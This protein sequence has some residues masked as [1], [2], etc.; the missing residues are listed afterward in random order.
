MDLELDLERFLMD[1]EM[2]DEENFVGIEDEKELSRKR[3]RDCY[4]MSLDWVKRVAKN[5]C[6]PAIGFVPG[7]SKW[8]AYGSEEVWK[9]VLLAKE[10]MQMKVNVDSNAIWEKKLKMH[11]DMYDDRATKSTTRCSRRLVSSKE[12]RLILFSRKSEVRDCYESSFTGS[13]SEIEPEDDFLASNYKKKWIPL[14]RY[15]QAEI[16]P[17]TGE[18]Y[19]TETRWLGTRVWPLEKTEHRS[20]LIER[21]QMGKGRQGSCGCEFVGSLECVRL[22]IAEKRSRVKLELGSAF[23]KWKFDKMGEEVSSKWTR[24]EEKKFAKIIKSNP[25][26]S[27]TS[28]WDELTTY[29]KN[30]TRPVLV[31]YYFNVYLL[32]RRAHQNRSNPSKVDSDDDELEKIGQKINESIGPTLCSPK[33]C[34]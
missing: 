7:M 30:K 32:R 17:W 25:K 27:G 21:E 13:R 24:H 12:T 14:G 34:I 3:K 16:P 18:T 10:A 2:K 29:F 6:D 4:L 26:S 9:Q 8:E 22:H 28:F 5:P 20:S 19:E 33:R 15:F 11:P 23:A 1:I 31:S